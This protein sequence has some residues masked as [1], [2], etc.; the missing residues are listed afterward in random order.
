MA[1]KYEEMCDV[2]TTARKEWLA[3]RERCRQYMVSLV[4]GMLSYCGIPQDRVA[5]LRWNEQEESYAE[6]EKGKYLLPGAMSFD[7]SGDCRLGVCIILTPPGT[8]P[9]RWA[10]FGLFVSE[11]DGK[12]LASVGPKK[13]LPIDLKDSSQCNKFYDAIVNSV[14]Q[15]FTKSE[16]AGEDL[17]GFKRSQIATED[18]PQKV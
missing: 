8:F 15:S 9:E 6:P 16:G 4:T 18:E 12:V 13:P 1:S 7:D 10:S 17:I 14:K 5:Y 11:Q 2:A 3:R